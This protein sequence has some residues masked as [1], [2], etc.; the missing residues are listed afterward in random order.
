MKKQC[1]KC[2]Q[3]KLLNEFYKHKRMKD[4]FLNKC[5]EC[6]KKD[7][8][9]N[10]GKYDNTEKGVI[11]IIYKT[12]V[13]NS[14]L[15]GHHLPKYTKKE[16]K[17]WMYKNKYKEIYDAWKKHGYKKDMKPSIDRLDSTKGYSFD[18]IELVTYRENMNRQFEDIRSGTGT[19]GKRCKQ[20]AQYKNGKEIARYVSFSQCKRIMGYSMENSLKNGK[21]DRHGYQYKYIN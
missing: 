5:K 1:F 2:K 7:V 8:A 12:Q 16:L 14:K 21:I 3:I 13:G 20:V 18:N 11:R 15:R 4:G 9:E 10:T 6:T 19:S 17:D